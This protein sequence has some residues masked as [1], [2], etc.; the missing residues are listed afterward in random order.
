MAVTPQSFRQQF[1]AFVDPTLYSD[2]AITMYVG[3][4]GSLFNQS[5]WDPNVIDFGTCLFVAHYM[6]LE[7]RDNMTAAAG[8]VP[9]AVTGVVT[10]KAVDKV[11][12]G[13]DAGV[14]TLADGGFWNMT[15]FGIDL[16]RLA[17]MMGAGGVQLGIGPP[18]PLTGVWGGFG[19][20][21]FNGGGCG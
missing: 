19:G 11:S 10:S 5:R 17:R 3:L 1:N 15:R 2:A 8:G 20:G 6:A 21:T 7:A 4:A 14:V 12:V 18:G 16:L 13:Y 9:G